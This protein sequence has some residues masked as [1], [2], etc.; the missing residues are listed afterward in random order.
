MSSVR[1]LPVLRSDQ[2]ALI[3]ANRTSAELHHPW[4]HPFTDKAGFD[5]YFGGLDGDRKIG[6]IARHMPAEDVVGV[7]N[8]SEIVRGAFQSAYLGFYGVQGQ[9]GR[10]L[11]TQA[12]V[13]VLAYA[14]SELELHRVEANVQPANRRSLALIERVGFRKEGYSP[15]YLLIDGSWQD[16]ER[17]A[18]LADEFTR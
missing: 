6:L 16:H 2:E 5:G 4:V 17:W 10:G 18:I 3:A 12:L 9:T 15:K 11:M 13:A 1:I 14:F 7:F 8:L